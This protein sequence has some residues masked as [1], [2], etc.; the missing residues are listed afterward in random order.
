M[1]LKRKLIKGGATL[2]LAQVAAQVC[3]LGRNIIIA[4]LVSPT[5]FGIAAIFLMVIY[6]LEMISNLSLN[7]LLVQAPD[8]NS[9]EFQRVGQ[10][11][12]AL[13]GIFCFIVLL[14]LAVPI[15]N[16]FSIPETKN[17][18]F[19]LAFIPL[20][21]GFNHMDP[22]RWERDLRYWP[23][24]SVELASQVISLV[25]AWPM[26]K[27]FGN[28]W[29]MLYLL[30]IK[31]IIKVVGSHIVAKRKYSWS[32][33]PHFMRRFFSFGWPLL[34]N[35][36]LMFGIFQG[37]RFIL[38]AAKKM[39]GS[40]YDMADV[41]LY[42][43]AFMIAMI[44]AL[45]CRRI[46]GFMALPILSK[47]QNSPQSFYEKACIFLQG[48]TVLAIAFG[49]FMLLAGN[50]LILFIYGEKYN[51]TWPLIAW[52][53]VFWT[54]GIMR[55]FP[56]NVAMALGNTIVLM[57]ANIIRLVSLIGIVFV[58]FYE[59]NIAWIA[60]VGA[61]G[62]LLAYFTSLLLNKFRLSIPLSISFKSSFILTGCLLFATIFRIT[63]LQ[64]ASVICWF[65]YVIIIS[66]TLP[67]LAIYF[68]PELRNT[69]TID[70]NYIIKNR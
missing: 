37:D 40:G 17:A 33:N 50:E 35:G 3:S 54:I 48:L 12:Q 70:S 9:A 34:I 44:P 67:L 18:F 59:L 36:L 20:L 60:A 57:Q 14:A 52:L 29:A 24:A 68:F 16:M 42:S 53:S 51:I 25:L 69:L 7:R 13:R 43:A 66:F 1:T 10:L 62:E 8:G 55:G 56:S 45:M 64:N 2:S 38:G 41:G 65:F 23:N 30:L 61:I 63:I 5:D 15:A 26:G 49:V 19:V 21:N 39:F 31:S 28:Y 27:L 11:L 4:R 46:F 58:V 47:E 22:R 6:F 32:R